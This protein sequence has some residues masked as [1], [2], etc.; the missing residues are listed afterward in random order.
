MMI[1]GETVHSPLPM[2]LPWWMP[3][4]FVFFGVL[5]IVLGVIGLALAVTVLQ[6]L[7]DAKA[8]EH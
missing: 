1:H 6:S 3:D 2:D 4:H 5:Y 7:R 8:A